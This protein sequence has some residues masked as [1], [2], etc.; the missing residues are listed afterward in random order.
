MQKV[1]DILAVVHWLIEEKK[2]LQF[3]LTGSSARKLRRTGVDLLAGR[4]LVK[5]MPPFFAKELGTTF[6]LQEALQLG[7]LPLVRGADN[8]EE[9][10]KAY[11]GMYLKE[12]VQ[13]EGLPTAAKN[14]RKS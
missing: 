1:P 7:L 13:A 8:P 10:L 12:E 11:A 4:A 14:L 5:H 6:H 9:T 3:I 2:G